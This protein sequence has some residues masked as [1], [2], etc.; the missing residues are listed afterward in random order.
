[1][2]AKAYARSNGS[3]HEKQNSD[4][5]AII[6]IPNNGIPV[7]YYCQQIHR[8]NLIGYST[9]ELSAD[10]ALHLM[11]GIILLTN[12]LLFILTLRYFYAASKWI[13]TNEHTKKFY[14]A[15]T[16]VIV[17]LNCITFLFDSYVISIANYDSKAQ[18]IGLV[19]KLLSLALIPSLEFA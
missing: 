5:S 6:A 10:I 4:R 11:M 13:Y 16:I 14:K 15:S 2:Q 7:D 12:I 18:K 19:F 3:D 17:L 9:Y 8:C 1:M